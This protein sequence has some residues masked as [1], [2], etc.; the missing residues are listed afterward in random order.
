MASI[1]IV[2]IVL[3]WLSYAV[4]LVINRLYFHPL[5]KFPGPRLAA[6]TRW[7]EFYYEVIQKGQFSKVID[8]YHEKYGNMAE[9]EVTRSSTNEPSRPDCTHC[10]R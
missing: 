1:F 6:A 4:C 8:Q 10:P 3:A 9:S 7:H 2:T 5:A